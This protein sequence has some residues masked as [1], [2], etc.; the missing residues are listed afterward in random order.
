MARR[1]GRNSRFYLG[2]ATSAAAAEPV[3]FVHDWAFNQVTDKLDV[4]AMGDANKTYVADLPDASGT[5]NGFYDDAT[6]QTYTAALDGQQRK[7]YLYTDIVNDPTQY[8]YGNGFFDFSATGGV[9]APLAFTASWNA[10]GPIT[11]NG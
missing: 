10:A 11:K 3:A 9:G 8:W 7:F 6:V 2:L 1:A 4:T 5:M